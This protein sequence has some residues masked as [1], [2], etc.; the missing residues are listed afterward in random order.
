[1]TFDG[2]AFRGGAKHHFKVYFQGVLYVEYDPRFNDC[3][4]SQLFRLNAISAGRK[5]GNVISARLIREPGI[6]VPV[7]VL[8][9]LTVACATTFLP[10]SVI[11]PVREAVVDCPC[12]RYGRSTMNMSAATDL[13]R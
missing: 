12:V 11:R 13:Q 3:F 7:L 1:M 2:H 10:G 9:T 5:I 8:K 4:K 6:R